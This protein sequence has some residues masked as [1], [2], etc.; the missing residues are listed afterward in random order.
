MQDAALEVSEEPSEMARVARVAAEAGG[1]R[2]EEARHQAPSWF[3]HAFHCCR[4]LFGCF[5]GRR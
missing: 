2:I 1:L 5:L 3:S 4:L